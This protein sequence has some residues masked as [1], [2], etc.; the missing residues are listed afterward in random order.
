MQDTDH[1]PSL[2]VWWLCDSIALWGF[3][4]C[5]WRSSFIPDILKLTWYH[6][7]WQLCLWIFRFQIHILSNNK[8]SSSSLHGLSFCLLRLAVFRAIQF[9]VCQLTV[10]RSVCCLE[11]VSEYGWLHA[12]SSSLVVCVFCHLYYI[13]LDRSFPSPYMTWSL[14]VHP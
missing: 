3:K 13:C 4:L 10:Y 7:F 2:H 12:V 8:S 6:I 5:S 9:L 11:F 1:L 14:T